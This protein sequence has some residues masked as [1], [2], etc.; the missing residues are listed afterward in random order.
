MLRKFNAAR[1]STPY[2]QVA[3]LL[4][5][6]LWGCGGGGGGGGGPAGLTPPPSTPVGITA[7]NA[8]QVS[9][10]AL[11]P[12]VAGLETTAAPQT[13][14]VTRALLA[15]A[16]DSKAQLSASQSVVGAAAQTIQCAVSGSVTADISADRTSG[17]F[18]FN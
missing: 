8:T 1:G 17:T 4:F 6:F 9:A 16:R 18:T 3:T 10:T 2:R 15:V 5:A 12:T 14:A 11:K 13:R 7:T